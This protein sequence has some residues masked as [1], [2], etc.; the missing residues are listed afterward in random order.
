MKPSLRHGIQIPQL[1]RAL[2]A[3]APAT[4]GDQVE[5]TSAALARNDFGGQSGR[6]LI[7]EQVRGQGVVFQRTRLPQTRLVDVR[8]EGCDFSAADWE[9]TRWRRIEITRSRGLGWQLLEAD[10]ENATIID[11]NLENCV[12]AASRLKNVRFEKCNLRG[13][14]LEQAELTSVVFDDCDLT[15]ADL[16][17][18]KLNTVDV[19]GSIIDALQAS[20]ADL[21]GA[22]IDRAQAAQIAA[23]FGLIVKDRDELLSD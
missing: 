9:K 23:L 3:D 4:L 13:A 2:S 17:G 21:R 8:F 1:P 14:I 16:R 22:I 20:A 11:C 15:H 6:G 19:R 18:A 7:F 10:L 12:L 5:F